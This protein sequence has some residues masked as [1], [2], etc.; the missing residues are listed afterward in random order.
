M[1][2]LYFSVFIFLSVFL[3][4]SC[5]TQAVKNDEDGI[6]VGTVQKEISVGMIASDVVT[7]LGSPNIVTTNDIG[8]ETWVYDKVSR[9]ISYENSSSG[10]SL[11]LIGAFNNSG[12]SSSSQKTLTIIINF[13]N[14][15]KVSTLKY[16]TST[17]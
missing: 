3:L 14:Q 4:Q 1:S 13:D 10:A 2:K 11:L 8:G 17:F 5:A 16:H 7:I 6:T 9:D 12:S 15:S